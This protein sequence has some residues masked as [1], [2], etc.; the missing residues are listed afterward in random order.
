MSTGRLMFELIK[1]HPWRWALNAI[2]WSAIWSMPVIAG[3]ITAE[4]FNRIDTGVGLNVPTLIVLI[5]AYGAGRIGVMTWGMHS[6]VNFMFR[7]QLVMK[8]NLFQRILEM[9]GAES[10]DEAQGEV[11]TRFRDDVEHVSEATD[12]TVDVAGVIVFAVAATIILTR[13][14]VTMTLLVFL[15]LLV[16][17]ALAER[18]GRTIRRYR[19]AAREATGRVTEAIGEIFGSVQSIKVAGAETSS[20][21]HLQRLNDERRVYEVRDQTLVA[22][23]ESLFWNTVNIGTGLVLL[24]AAARLQSGGD[25]G[26]GDFALFVFFIGIATDAVNIAG[27]FIARVRQASV[28][29]DRLGELLGEGRVG[30]VVE[31]VDLELKGELPAI[32]QVERN[33]SR[34][35]VLGVRSLSYTYPGSGNGIH[36]IDLELRRGSFTV[37]TGKIGSGKTTLLRAVLGL[38][39]ASGEITWNGERVD[40]PATFF[41][42]PR[43]AYT[44]QVP[45]LLSMS[46]RDNLRLGSDKTDAEVM[47]AIAAAVMVP[48]MEHMPS[49]LDTEVGPLGVRLSGG[50][51]QRTAA[52]RMMLRHPDLMVFDDLSS[53]LDVTTEQQLWERLFAEDP[54]VTSLVVSHRRAAMRRADQIVVMRDGHVE[55]AGTLEELVDVSEELRELWA[56]D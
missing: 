44:P 17:I 30:E 24:V 37:V 48:D 31:K 6:D 38:V 53:A 39:P 19:K 21:A 46:L 26:L 33:G 8:K 5:L 29:F 32:T 22:L 3:L 23:L 25:F 4:F 45:K 43:A 56:T 52:A 11:I 27:L 49:G 36:G 9:P 15:P 40:D 35:D 10:V 42:P 51:I 14:D 47:D 55:A 34:L 41:V 20:I 13:I 2:L 28:S 12:F 7:L 50:Q 54:D 18:T 1:T 16:V